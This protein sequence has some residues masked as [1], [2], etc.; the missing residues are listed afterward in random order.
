MF[1]WYSN[2]TLYTHTTRSNL[3]LYGR[4]IH[5]NFILCRNKH[6]NLNL[7]R[8]NVH[9][10]LTLYRHYIVIWPY[11]D[12]NIDIWIY[13]EAKYIIIWPYIDIIYIVIWLC[14][15]IEIWLCI[16]YISTG[17]TVRDRIPVGMRFS[18]HPDRPCGPPNLLYNRYR[19]FPGGKVR[20]GRAANHS[21]LLVPR[22]RKSRAIPLPTLWATPGL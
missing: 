10:N 5:T 2:L 20:P 17:W 21:P 9:S 15:D 11:V 14:M 18:T 16:Y 8:C 3:T 19:V 6:R 4:N 7:Y 13:I 1:I 12:T 22:S